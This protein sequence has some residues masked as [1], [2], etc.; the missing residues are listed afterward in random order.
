MKLKISVRLV[1]STICFF[2]AV[3]TGYLWY[4]YIHVRK[5]MIA[6][7][8]EIVTQ[9]TLQA[10]SALEKMFQEL[11]N[12]ATFLAD[13]LSQSKVS[14]TELEQLLADNSKDLNL[15]VLFAPHAFA[16]QQDLYAP[17][18]VQVAGEKHLIQL[19]SVYDYTKTIRYT[20]PLKGEAGYSNSYLDMATNTLVVEYR[21]PFYDENGQLKGVA[22]ASYDAAHIK[23]VIDKLDISRKG[24]VSIT[25]EAGKR[26]LYHPNRSYMLENTPI[27]ELEKNNALIAKLMKAIEK[28]KKGLVEGVNT[29]TDQMSWMFYE[30]LNGTPWTFISTFVED[31]LG[32]QTKSLQQV[33][34][35][36][37]IGTLLLLLLILLLAMLLYGSSRFYI[38]WVMSI[39]ASF[40]CIAAMIVVW[41]LAVNYSC[42][43]PPDNV[44]I[45]S[46]PALEKYRADLAQ[47]ITSAHGGQ[48]FTGF[49][50][51]TEL[52]EEDSNSSAEYDKSGYNFSVINSYNWAVKDKQLIEIPTG[53]YV[54]EVDFNAALGINKVKVSGIL[55][56]R[57][58]KGQHDAIV[59]G[60]FF[61]QALESDMQQLTKTSLYNDE[62][63]T[64]K[65]VATLVQDFNVR[66][67]PFDERNINIRIFSKDFS[68]PVI[69]IPDLAAYKILAPTALPQLTTELRTALP[70]WYFEKTFFSFKDVL[71]LTNFGYYTAD[72]VETSSRSESVDLF[73]NIT[74]KRFIASTL[75]LNLIPIIIIL[76][77][78][79]LVLMLTGLG[80]L[81]IEH[82]LASVAS[83]FFTAMLAYNRFYEDVPVQYNVFLGSF[84]QMVEVTLFIVAVITMLYLRNVKL[85]IV[86]YHKML[87]PR[88]LFWPLVSFWCLLQSLLY[89]Y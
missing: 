38:Y 88:L 63:V 3:G 44:M 49:S 67:Y 14:K 50:V 43:P 29:V 87:L 24:Y 76:M 55:W 2:V 11:K 84:Y 10:V 74:L 30:P 60:V 18:S 54:S 61:P 40:A 80:I 70:E 16:Q 5:T 79:F 19:E 27:L 23:A 72:S 46:V 51:P 81:K 39:T 82:V 68:K 37:M 21:A 26:Y 12:K 15:G 53:I 9:D 77:L 69:L 64:W 52:I 78:L 7:T 83:L 8:K 17:Y 47:E 28:G 35:K 62:L 25:E 85:S 57:F 58:K 4:R 48:Q 65:F 42:V 13:H 56:Q 1:L 31:D 45:D 22:F 89:F 20:K 41:Y 86:T 6:K 71:Y 34:L 73:L 36:A 66:N 59:R 75:L 33:F 32:L